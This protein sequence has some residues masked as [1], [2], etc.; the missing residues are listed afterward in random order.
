MKLVIVA[1]FY[2]FIEELLVER[3]PSQC[4]NRSLI[5]IPQVAD[6]REANA[7]RFKWAFFDS[8]AHGSR[9]VLVLLA[10]I[11]RGDYI[12][13][14]LLPFVR[15]GYFRYSD[16]T[17]DI[18]EFEDAK[19]HDPLIRRI[20][21][22][23][24]PEG[25]IILATPN[26][27]L[28]LDRW[29]K[30]HLEGKLLLHPR[31]LR[32]ARKSHFEAPNLIFESLLILGNEYRDVRLQGESECGEQLS[33]RLNDLDLHLTDAISEASAGQFGDTYRV[34][35]PPGQLRTKKLLAQ[36]IKKGSDRDERTCL[37]VYF[38]WDEKAQIVV[39]G[40]LPSHLDIRSS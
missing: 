36:H 33:H 27:L 10:V 7:K 14:T 40:W 4:A 2:R 26:D 20:E 29:T 31:A 35:Y 17:V 24:L 37:R 6:G 5:W 11:R 3:F 21:A 19:S 34:Y 25:R 18:I 1:G 15:E 8:L 39:V 13:D 16:L 22:F 28:Q 38:F 12:K 23:G 32:G 30:E 9:D